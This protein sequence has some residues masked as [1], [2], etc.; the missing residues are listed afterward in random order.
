MS[1]TAHGSAAGAAVVVVMPAV[2]AGLGIGS[3]LASD[4]VLSVVGR[5]AS[6]TRARWCAAQRVVVAGGRV[7]VV[8]D[9]RS[10]GTATGARRS[11]EHA[12]SVAT[13][14]STAA[15]RRRL[16]SHASMMAGGPCPEQR[17]PSCGRCCS[18]VSTA[19]NRSPCS[20]TRA[21]TSA[22]S[23]RSSSV[24]VGARLD[25]VPRHRRRHRRLGPGPQR[26]RGDRR[27]VVGVLAPVDE[28]LPRPHGLGHHRRDLLGQLLLEHLPDGEGEVGGL[29]VGHAGRVQRHV[30]LQ[31][32]R[33]RRLAPALELD[34]GEHL[35]DLQRRS[36]QQ[37]LMSVVGPGVE[38]EHH[39]P[40]ACRGRR[41]APSAR[42][43]RSPPCWP[44]TPAPPCS[45]MQ[46]YSMPPLRSPGPSATGDPLGAV[47]RAALL[48][49]A[50][51]RRCRWGSA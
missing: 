27:L 34:G 24:A 31:A 10:G 48:E 45:S 5:P 19:A 25:L 8:V 47:L 2:G 39:R 49:E 22:A 43:A 4:G 17:H 32:L 46:Q 1:N 51:G 13:A 42:A 20:A 38:V 18:T 7:V 23:K 33:A 50:L 29:L 44:P 40:R 35:A 28:D 14:T 26:V 6:S 16:Q 41:P 36:A 12:A 15:A 3:T 21:S 9:G 11:A 37:S 30:Q